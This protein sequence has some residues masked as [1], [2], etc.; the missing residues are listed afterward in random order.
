M[1]YKV[2]MVGMADG[3]TRRH[4]YEMQR[5]YPLRFCTMT[6]EIEHL[7]IMPDYIKPDC[8]RCLTKK[9]SLYDKIK[10]E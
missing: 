2:L 7:V 1:S 8:K 3:D 6:S 9:Q 10:P 5:G 4:W